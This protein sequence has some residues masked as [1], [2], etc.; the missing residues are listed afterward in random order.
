MPALCEPGPAPSPGRD[1]LS[2]VYNSL[3]ESGNS[4][5]MT[6]DTYRPRP[7][8]RPRRLQRNTHRRRLG[9][10]CAG[11][12]DYT[13]WDVNLIRFLFLLS[14]FFGGLGMGIYLALW[15][16]LPSTEE[17]PLPRVSWSLRRQLGRLRKQVRRI[18]RKHDALVADPVLACFESVKLITADFEADSPHPA[19][20]RLRQLALR[21]FPWLLDRILA[22]PAQPFR[23]PP[24]AAAEAVLEQ[25]AALGQS[26][27]AAARAVVERD[28][29]ASLG[30][31]RPDTPEL[32]A[33][34]QTL[35][36]L[37]AQ[38][39]ARSGTDTVAVLEGIADKL[40]FLLQ[41]LEQRPEDRDLLDLRPHEIRKIAFEYL[42]DALNE[43][44]RLPAD[45]ARTARLRGGKTAEE[46]LGDQ[47][48]LLDS[49]LHDLAKSLFERD[50]TGLLVHGRFLREKFAAQP[51]RLTDSPTS[52]PSP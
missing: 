17:L 9:G 18:N 29:L 8:D 46:A 38:L 36:P 13:G 26:F 1:S 14:M 47:L 27:E 43:Y 4:A 25:L 23:E 49:T 7:P 41:R 39:R 48:R 12:A 32:A 24:S 42:P 35:A 50:A 30:Q 15:L 5:A 34:R 44:L 51:F 21:Q 52:E 6:P 19:D 37:E 20:D 22:M 2:A 11:L 31:R 40:G 45:L 16:A 10:V 33:W 3:T 28:F